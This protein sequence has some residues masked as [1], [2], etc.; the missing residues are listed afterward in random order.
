MFLCNE[1]DKKK[2][3]VEEEDHKRV[4]SFSFRVCMG[5]G[6]NLI[7][8]VSNL[9]PFFLNIQ[10]VTVLLSESELKRGRYREKKDTLAMMWV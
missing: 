4:Y 2:Q 6:S 9:L 1:F 3:C 5:M 10:S 7:L 8:V